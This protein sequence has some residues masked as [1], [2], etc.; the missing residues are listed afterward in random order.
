M[1]ADTRGRV[2]AVFR[3]PTPY[4]DPLFDRLAALPGLDL[5]VA[6]LGRAFV[7]TPWEAGSLAHRHLFPRAILRFEVRGHELGLHPGLVGRFLRRRPDAVVL[8]GWF[9]PTTLALAALCRLAGVP[10]VLCS[11]SFAASGLA[12]VSPGL[13]ARV[14][15]AVVRGASAWLPAG[16]RARD[17]LVRQGADPRRCHFFPTA[18]DARLWSAAIA[19]E[20]QRGHARAELGLP[21][22]RVIVFV[23][24]L[25]EDKAPDVL[26]DA[27]GALRARGRAVRLLVVGEGPLRVRLEGHPA[28]ADAVFLGFRQPRE[29]AR[30]L[31]AADAL[32]LPSRYE[33][34]GAVVHEALAGGLPVVVSD[35]VG[36]GADLVADGTVGAVVRAGDAAALAG[37]IEDVLDRADRRTDLPGRAR[38]RAEEWGHDLAAA[39]LL[40]AL[41]D[42]GVPGAGLARAALRGGAASAAMP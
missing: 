1:A 12:G 40:A 15:R 17:F 20:R 41:A 30:F 28:A 29:L 8:S 19:A 9:D 32:V 21:Q 11:E 3:H 27:V 14:R 22:D 38:R 18:P 42:V 6:Y 4:R 37:G 5:E 16:S 26:L 23:G 13:A 33:T 10:Y 25:V 31:A 36:S 2:L 34:W 35:R 39:S 7:Q 24:R